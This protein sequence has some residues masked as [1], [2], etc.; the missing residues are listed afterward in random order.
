[1]TDTNQIELNQ[2]RK[3]ISDD[4]GLTRTGKQIIYLSLIC[5]AI[6]FSGAT[7]EKANTFLFE[8]S[9]T[10]PKGLNALMILVLIFLILRYNGFATNYSSKLKWIS[11]N[12]L[13]N[14]PEIMW[15]NHPSGHLQGVMGRII[16][17]FHTK[18]KHIRSQSF[19]CSLT[20]KMHIEIAF[21]D[22][23]GGT[24]IEV[25]SLDN[26][27]HKISKKEKL[28]LIWCIA[29]TKIKNFTNHPDHLNLLAPYLIGVI[30]ITTMLVSFIKPELIP[31]LIQAIT[32]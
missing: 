27:P 26:G 29:S 22:V 1:M 12:R 20:L 5:L 28:T 11:K 24:H 21:S 30:A 17:G 8:I 15:K 4:S 19:K 18:S 3:E 13:E 2:I 9:F 10:N 31:S 16:E 6:T 25:F 32:S 7:I 14:N 23:M